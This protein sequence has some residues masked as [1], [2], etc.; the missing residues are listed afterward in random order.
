MNQIVKYIS[1]NALIRT[2]AALSILGMACVTAS[3]QLTLDSFPN[4]NSGNPYVKT[5]TA[6]QSTTTHYEGLPS[7]S[8]LGAARETIFSI[9]AN[10]YAQTSTIDVG[11][12]ILIVDTGF[13]AVAGLDIGYGFS[14]SGKEVPMGLNLGAYSGL[15]VNF[16]GVASTEAINVIVVVYP[17]SGGYYTA[18]T[19]LYP[20]VDA[21]PA[22]FLYTSF[23]KGGTGA[24]LTPTEASNINYIIIEIETAGSTASYGITSFQAIN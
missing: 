1:R 2:I 13:Q 21:K 22:T 16:A 9:G 14:T 12:N 18:E 24:P 20:N 15:Q 7:G 5:L 17:N 6:A 23:S 4:G 8:L 11:G 3:A 10:P 19:T